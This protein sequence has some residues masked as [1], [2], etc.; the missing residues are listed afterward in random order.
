[1]EGDEEKV[2]KGGKE[3]VTKFQ[4]PFIMVE[5]DISMLKFHQTNVLEFLKFFE[6]NGYKFS[7]VG[8]LSK[9]Y[10]SSEELIKISTTN[11]NVFIVY[12]KFLQ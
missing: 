9:E 12:E 2:I 5:Y 6:N 7:L 8:F 1:M 4:V 10:I 3:I 11:T